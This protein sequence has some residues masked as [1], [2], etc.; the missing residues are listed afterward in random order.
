MEREREGG[1]EKE[2]VREGRMEKERGEGEREIDGGRERDLERGTYK[3]RDVAV[4]L[5]HG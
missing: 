1:R 4:F 2:R 5:H 3:M